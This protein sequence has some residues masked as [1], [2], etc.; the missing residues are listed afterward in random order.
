MKKIQ[1]ILI[2][3]LFAGFSTFSFAEGKMG[4]TITGLDAQGNA[5]EMSRGNEQTRSEDLQGAFFSFFIEK[6]VDTPVGSMALGIDVNPMDIASGSVSNVRQDGHDDSQTNTAEIEIV[7][8]IGGYVIMDLGDTGAYF[9][10]YGV[11]S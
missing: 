8:N 11:F 3:L 1:T 5:E 6:E 9:K 7:D 2:T 10:S 4:L